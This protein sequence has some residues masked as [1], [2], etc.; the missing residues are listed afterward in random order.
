MNDQ[1]LENSLNLALEATKGELE[2]SA[3]LEAGFDRESGSWELIVRYNGD[4]EEALAFLPEVEAQILTGGYA[5]LR[6]P[7]PLVDSLAALPQIEYVEKPKLLNFA[8]NQGR[9]ASCM[10]PVQAGPD[11]LT[12]RGVIVAVIDSGIDFFHE[13]FRNPDG[14][15]R[16]LELWDQQLER[17]FTRQEINEALGQD[18]R[19]K[20][21]AL[22]PSRDLS[23]HGTAVAGIAAGTAVRAGEPTAERR[24]RAR[25]WQSV[26]EFRGNAPFREP[27]S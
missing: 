16:L 6:V 13:D 4:L 1:K 22:V 18:S 21:E 5:V 9:T 15:T 2:K 20:G 11:G 23:G 24:M 26:W 7:E 12:G 14:T 17:V 8:V 27:R 10:N 3:E 25:F 19:E